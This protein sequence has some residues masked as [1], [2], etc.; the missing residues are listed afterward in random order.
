[1][2]VGGLS[3]IR[4]LP[5]A[6]VGIVCVPAPGCGA[7]VLDEL[8]IFVDIYRKFEKFGTEYKT[9]DT[10][11]RCAGWGLSDENI[12]SFDNR[13]NAFF[14]ALKSANVGVHLQ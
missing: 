2:A 11:F 10:S 4:K 7:F 13:V 1:M 6:I 8:K 12:D 14:H 5:S 9:T 3:D